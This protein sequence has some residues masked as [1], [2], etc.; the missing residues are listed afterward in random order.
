MNNYFMR[1]WLAAFF[2]LF[3]TSCTPHQQDFR[4]SAFPPALVGDQF[5]ASDGVALP[6]RSWLPQGRPKAAVVAL[7]GMNDYAQAF[8][9]PGPHLARRG[10]AVYAYD[11]RGFGASPQPGIWPGEENLRRD[12]REFIQVVAQQHRHT[13]IYVLGESMGGAVAVSMLGRE[14][15]PRIAGLILLAPALWGGEHMPDLYRLALWVTV[16]TFPASR[17]DGSD[18]K[19]LASN[20]IPMLRGMLADPLVQKRTRADAIYGL[21]RLMDDAYARAGG[22]RVP[23]LLLYGGNDQVIP[24]A[25]INGAVDRLPKPMDLAYYPDGYHMLM[26]DI[27][28]RHVANDVAAWIRHPDRLRVSGRVRHVDKENNALFSND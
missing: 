3:V 10:L 5:T 23:V 18:L 25:T 21:V 2:L 11:Q 7:H 27:Q 19:I 14:D 20:N 17:Y 12:L 26:R 8:A 24:P 6:V 28:G 13:P 4:H 22:V 15:A 1:P 9:L 16:H